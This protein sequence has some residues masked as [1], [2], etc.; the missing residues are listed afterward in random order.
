MSVRRSSAAAAVAVVCAVLAL[1]A[2]S[3]W[4]SA[5]RTIADG[6]EYFT[7]TDRLLVDLAGPISVHLLKLDP[8]K[9]RLSSVH[10]H[11]EIMG[12]ETVDSLA[13]R[14]RAVVAINGGFFN[15]TNGDPTYVLKEAGKLVSDTTMVKGAVIIRSPTRGKTEIEFDQVS[16]TRAIRFKAAGKEWTVP[17]AGTNTT[18]ARGRLMMYTPEYHAD[19]DTAANGTEW[20]LAGTPLKVTA[21]RRNAGHTP[22]PRDGFVLSYGGLDLPPDLAALVVGTSLQLLTTWTTVNGVSASRLNDADDIVTGAGLLRVKGRVLSNWEQAEHL[23]PEAFIN[24]RHP[25]T[26]IGLDRHAAI[27]L[28]AV[29]GRQPD[30]SVGMTL[31]ELQRLCDR[32]QLT[33]ALNLDGGGSTTMVVNGSIVNRPS[34]IRAREVSDALIV[35]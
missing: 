17:I 20:L 10:A 23:S 24:L 2:Q 9:I 13:Q 29:D 15:L 18:R 25:R 26:L 11:D 21:V 34:E 4:L 12:R 5:G 30:H 33:D 8:A 28:A 16:A 27:W 3:T 32:L 6:I 22:I 1:S 14:H 31:P 7:S 19:T 35:K